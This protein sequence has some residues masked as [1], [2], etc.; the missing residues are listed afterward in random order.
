MYRIYHGYRL[1]CRQR[2]ITWRLSRRQFMAVTATNCVY[3]GAPPANKTWHPNIKEIFFYSGIDRKDNARGYTP[4]NSV[5]CC[6]RCNSIKGKHLTYE[7]MLTVMR[8][9]RGHGG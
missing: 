1:K 9:L 6:G 8:A 5:A 7:Q 2:G 4:E 3:C